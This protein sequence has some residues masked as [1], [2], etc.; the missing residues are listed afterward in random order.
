MLLFLLIRLPYVGNPQPLLSQELE[1][2]LV[3]EKLNEGLHL[4]NEILTQIGPF[5]AFVYQMVDLWAGKSQFIYES[6]ALVLI[7]IQTLY[8]VFIVNRRNLLTEKN[9]VSGMF[10][11]ILMSISFDI[12]KLSP[13]LLANTFILIALNVTLR[14]IEKR[15]GLGDDIFEIGL[16]LGIATLFHL[17]SFIF[18]F[19]AIIVLFLYTGVNIR[20]LFMV[21]LA[22]FL[23]LFLV[24]IFFYFKEHN[25]DFLNIWLFNFNN[26]LDL[27]LLGIKDILITFSLPLLFT[28]LGIF[29]VLTVSRYNSFQNRSHQL[30][31]IFGIFSFISLL[32]SKEF[33]PSNLVSS[34]SFLSLFVS[35]FFLHSKRLFFQEVLSLIFIFSVLGIQYVGSNEINNESLNI[36]KNYKVKDSPL[37]KKYDN[38]KIFITGERIDAYKSHKMATGYLS[39]ELAKS[40]FE[41][42]NNYVSIVNIYTNFKKDLPEVIIDNEGVMEK[43]FKNIPTLSSKYTYTG[44]NIYELKIKF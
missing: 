39:W 14:Q 41:N 15:D 6:L 29:R 11:L 42:P 3:G 20:Q 2:M 13:S 37:A 35:G 22:F 5:S 17:S 19:W 12:Q 34:L 24:Y 8:F 31:I 25:S 10:F 40:D 44:E 26:V 33:I 32:F 43:V 23:P 36:L 21:L 27:S 28:I 4:Y 18:I 30:L 9:Y 1:S 38:N 16:F 7:F